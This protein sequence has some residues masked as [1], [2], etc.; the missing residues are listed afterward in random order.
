MVTNPN[1]N[2]NPKVRLLGEGVQLP[3]QA[4][5]FEDGSAPPRRHRVASGVYR[6]R[7]LLADRRA[8]SKGGERA[9]VEAVPLRVPPPASGEECAQRVRGDAPRDAA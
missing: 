8:R 4:M 1:P 6:V 2:P 3:H 5:C 7:S 9:P